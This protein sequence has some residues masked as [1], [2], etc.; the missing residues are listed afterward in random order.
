M[1]TSTLAKVAT[2][3]GLGAVDSSPQEIPLSHGAMALVDAMDYDRLVAYR[4][5]LTAYGYA[6][7]YDGH[8]HQVYM[9]R[10]ITDAPK[11]TIVHHQD[12]SKLNN[13]RANLLIME[14]DVHVQRH[15]AGKQRL[16]ETIEKV[17]E[18]LTG[19]K[20]SP[21]HRAKLSN[22]RK[23]EWL[24]M[25]PE[26]RDAQRSRLRHGWAPETRAKLSRAEQ[27][28]KRQ[29]GSSKYVG[30]G[31]F[32]RDGRWRAYICWNGKHLHLGYFDSEIDAALAYDREARR[33]FGLFA[34]VNFARAGE[35]AA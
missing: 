21:E 31:W 32:K 9:H 22:I 29:R 16:P 11:G 28:M 25:S 33:L 3:N 15:L 5:H 23:Q 30:V 27:G 19:R 26:Q 13:T 14:R 10:L 20:L 6:A 17:R 24:T 4:W 18:A 34:R 1:G 7:A 8:G 2:D 12:G 35:E